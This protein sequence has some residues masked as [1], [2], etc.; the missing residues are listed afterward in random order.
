MLEFVG[1]KRNCR[2][3][4]ANVCSFIYIANVSMLISNDKESPQV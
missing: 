3:I 2:K 4:L 1:D